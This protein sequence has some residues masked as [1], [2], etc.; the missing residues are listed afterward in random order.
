MLIFNTVYGKIRAT[1]ILGGIIFLLLFITLTYHKYR[2]EKQIVSAAQIQFTHEVNS[3][4]ELNSESMMHTLIDNVYWTDLVY[5]VERNDTNW[6]KPNM[7]LVAASFFDC[8]IIT[9]SKFGIVRQEAGPTVH[10]EIAVPNGLLEKLKTIR[11]AHFFL[12]TS[13]GLMEI[14]AGSIHPSEDLEEKKTPPH[15]YMLLIKKWDQKF[16][17]HLASILGSGIEIKPSPNSGTEG[18]SSIIQA[19]IILANW[20]GSP[21]VEVISHKDLDLNFKLMQYILYIILGFVFLGLIVAN[22]I[23]RIWIFKP[24]HLVTDVLSTDNYQSISKLKNNQAEFGNIG[25]LFENY[26]LQKKELQEA[27]EQAEKSDKLKSAFLANMSHEIRTPMNSILGFSELLEEEADEQIRNQYLKI[28]QTNGDSLLKL[29]NDLIDLSKIE[30]GDLIINSR[31]FSI[32]EMFGE[33]RDIYSLEL[34]KRKKTEVKLAGE[35]PHGDLIIYSDMHR[36][37]QVLS[38]LLTNAIKFTVYGNITFTCQKENEEFIFSVA[39]T[40]TGIPEEDQKI[41]FERFIKFNY[42][43]LNSEGSGIGLAIVEN[44]VRMLNGRLWVKSVYG[45]GSTFFFSIPCKPF[46]DHLSL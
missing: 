11:T 37:K 42:K 22:F 9:N 46:N 24:L 21:V 34:E 27:K 25:H 32:K 20:D 18:K 4:L 6:F 31:N 38:N 7:S 29:L 8:L 36:I 41:I 16:L 19:K 43:W 2:L 33:L 15:G 28:I 39:D 26:V 12:S 35:L 45:E 13:D 3:L 30:A 40:G 14:C 1:I 5:A 44:I 23:S 10:S 17:N